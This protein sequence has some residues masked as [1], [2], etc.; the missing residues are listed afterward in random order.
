M[1]SFRYLLCTLHLVSA[2]QSTTR[3]GIQISSNVQMRLRSCQ[4]TDLPPIG[5]LGKT[6]FP[7]KIPPSYG[8]TKFFLIRKFLKQDCGT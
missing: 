6:S 2:D 7:Q 5:N 4:H 1:R 8:N 3:F